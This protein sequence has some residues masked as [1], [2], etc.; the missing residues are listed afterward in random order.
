[1]SK[2]AN[3]LRIGLAQNYGADF[4]FVDSPLQL[5][6]TCAVCAVCHWLGAP[7]QSHRIGR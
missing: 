1:M 3:K 4:V 2:T 5:F 7:T 6:P